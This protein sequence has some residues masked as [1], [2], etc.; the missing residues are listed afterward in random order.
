MM[1][2]DISASLYLKNFDSLQSDS[3]KC[4]PQYELNNFVTMATYWVPD[5]PNI[6]W[7]SDHLWHSILIFA[8]GTS[9]VWSSKHMNLLA[10]V[11]GII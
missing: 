3:N 6:T 8:N 4:A 2:K 1:K 5:L 7:F 11:C 9:Y 10:Q